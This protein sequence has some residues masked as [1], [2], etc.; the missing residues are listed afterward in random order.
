M[1]Q[2]WRMASVLLLAI[3]GRSQAQNPSHSAA[4][5]F[6]DVAQETTLTGTVAGVFTK[7][8]PG[9]LPGSHLTLTTPDSSVD[10]SLG[11]FA[12]VGKGSVSVSG[13]QQIEVTG[14]LKNL[15]GKPVFF[16]R[17]LKVGDNVYTLRNAHGLPVTPNSHERANQAQNGETR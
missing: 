8:T 17:L 2:V 1:R 7:A 14:I 4:P 16:A 6:Y 9:M 11:A 3:V 5:L 12:F 10:V 15:Q 13:G